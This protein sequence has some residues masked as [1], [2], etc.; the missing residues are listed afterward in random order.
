MWLSERM[1]FMNKTAMN[2]IAR[3][4]DTTTLEKGVR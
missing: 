1:E 2:Q 4:C 3:P